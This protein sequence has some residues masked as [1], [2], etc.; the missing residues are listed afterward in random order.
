MLTRARSGLQ[1]RD[2]LKVMFNKNFGS[3]FRT[4]SGPTLF[5][6]SILRYRC[7]RAARCC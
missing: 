6:Q 1:V 3:V 2:E 5:T 7:A 4:H